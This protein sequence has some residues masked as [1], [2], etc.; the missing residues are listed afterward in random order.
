MGEISQLNASNFF[1][2]IDRVARRGLE[3]RPEHTHRA[4]VRRGPLH[5]WLQC[6]FLSLT[7]HAL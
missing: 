3:G 4:R 6:P 5:T 7:G 2:S 1:T